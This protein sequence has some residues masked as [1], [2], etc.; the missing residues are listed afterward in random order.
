MGYH[1]FRFAVDSAEDARR[2]FDSVCRDAVEKPYA[3]FRYLSS[4]GVGATPVSREEVAFLHSHGVAVGLVWNDVGWTSAPTGTTSMRVTSVYALAQES[5][6]RAASAARS[7]SAPGGVA[8]WAD[9]EYGIAVDPEWLSGWAL[10]VRLEGFLPGF[11]ASMQAPYWRIPWNRARESVG[12]ALL[13]CADWDTGLQQATAGRLLANLR[14]PVLEEPAAVYQVAGNAY[15]GQVDLDVVDAALLP[16]VA[17]WR[18]VASPA[19]AGGAVSLRPADGWRVVVDG[20]A[21]TA[22]LALAEGDELLV[23]IRSICSALGAS[24]SVH[25][26]TAAVSSGREVQR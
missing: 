20:A 25:G 9:L 8:L 3:W 24:V 17:L 15:G 1:S 23:G 2:I 21:I 5:A 26:H 6:R 13:W 11:Y 14:L 7:V 10:E 22:P 18:P 19:A 16:S 4:G 12:E